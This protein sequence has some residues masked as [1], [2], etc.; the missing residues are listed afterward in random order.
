MEF[1]T[2]LALAIIKIHYA[3]FW[4]HFLIL[5]YQDFKHF[6]DYNLIRVSEII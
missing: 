2:N 4:H 1:I 5:F 6:K 3:F